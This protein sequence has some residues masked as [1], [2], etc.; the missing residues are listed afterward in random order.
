MI[1]KGHDLEGWRIAVYWKDEHTFYEG[2]VEEYDSEL[3]QHTV[4][5]NDGELVTT[6]LILQSEG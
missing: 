3:D 2:T 1:P 6:C 4:S 5:Y